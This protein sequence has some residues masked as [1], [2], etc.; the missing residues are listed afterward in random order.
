MTHGGKKLRCLV[1]AALASAAAVLGSAS[2]PATPVQPVEV[3]VIGTYH[4]DHLLNKDYT[5]THLRAL[6]SKVAADAVAIEV[7]PNWM[8]SRTKGRLPRRGYGWL[9][10]SLHRRLRR[11]AAKRVTHPGSRR[12][13]ILARGRS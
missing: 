2:W 12:L 8:D 1:P 13:A 10:R 9:C 6:L 5:L 4:W 3:V 11:H 7:G